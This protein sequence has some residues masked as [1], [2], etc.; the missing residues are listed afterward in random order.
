MRGGTN[1]NSEISQWIQAA[2]E[3]IED[4]ISVC[5]GVANRD[6]CEACTYRQAALVSLTKSGDFKPVLTAQ[7]RE[8]LPGGDVATGP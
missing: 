6:A 8:Q 2:G 3:F 1:M 4:E 5:C 7:F